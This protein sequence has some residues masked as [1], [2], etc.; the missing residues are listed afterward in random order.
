MPSLDDLPG[1]S[2][3]LDDSILNVEKDH[4][5]KQ[6]MVVSPSQVQTEKWIEKPWGIIVRWCK[7]NDNFTSQGRRL[8]FCKCTLYHFE[9]VCVGSEVEL[10][11]L[12]MDLSVDCQFRVCIQ[13]DGGH[14]WRFWSIPQIGHSTLVPHQWTAR[15]KGYSLR[16]WRK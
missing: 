15:F 7:V 8:R 14:E 13:G 3:Q 4:I 16:G 12:H 5:F 2:A 11:V 9:D 6:G 1:L 10:T